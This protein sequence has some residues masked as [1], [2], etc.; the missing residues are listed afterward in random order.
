MDHMPRISH[1]MKGLILFIAGLI[2]FLYVTNI[3]TIGLQTVIF[4]ASI[5]LMIAGF[6]EMDGYNKVA[7]LLHKKR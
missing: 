1:D 3:V 5:L 7:R 6:L 2:L 4:V